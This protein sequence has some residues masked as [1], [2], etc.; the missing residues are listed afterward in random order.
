MWFMAVVIG[1]FSTKVDRFSR[2]VV[3]GAPIFSVNVVPKP[4]MQSVP[5]IY[6]IGPLHV[7]AS[8]DRRG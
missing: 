1:P 3:Q 4:P 8:E 6:V 2:I 7:A 5:A